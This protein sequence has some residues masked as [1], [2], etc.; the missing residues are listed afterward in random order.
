MN[1]SSHEL[2]RQQEENELLRQMLQDLERKRQAE[3]LAAAVS[4][5]T[6]AANTV[7]VAQS[8]VPTEEEINAN[9]KHFNETAK[10]VEHVFLSK[11]Q[12][13]VCIENEK[14]CHSDQ[15]RLCFLFTNSHDLSKLL[16]VLHPTLNKCFGVKT[17]WTH[18]KCALTEQNP[19]LLKNNSGPLQFN[20]IPTPLSK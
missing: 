5:A 9:E 16:I 6:T 1:L 17:S 11:H 12:P 4:A 19:C 18:T 15:L 20:S 10:R 14:V 13:N 7:S 8:M 3:S 2:A